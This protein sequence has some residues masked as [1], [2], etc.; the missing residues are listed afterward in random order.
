MD[1]ETIMTFNIRLS[2]ILFI[3]SLMLVYSCKK[4]PCATKAGFL[5]HF[6]AFTTE[7][8]EKKTSMDDEGM[9]NFEDRYKAL[10]NDC[11]KQH[12][13]D[14]TLK[15]RQDFWKKSLAFYV[16]RYDGEFSTVLLEK[17]DDPFNQYLKDELIDITKESGMT[18]ILSLQSIVKEELPKLMEVFADE[19]EKFGKELFGGS[20]ND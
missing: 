18:F 1:N 12:K 19:I 10:I 9:Q 11:Y 16:D 5:E 2:I 15:E 17:L 13:A 14:M 4:D 6:S 8:E 20:V 7:F 3:S